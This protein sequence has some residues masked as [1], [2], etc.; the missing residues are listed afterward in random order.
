M[1]AMNANRTKLNKGTQKRVCWPDIFMRLDSGNKKS[2]LQRP[3]CRV[4]SAVETR[5]WKNA[6][7]EATPGRNYRHILIFSQTRACQDSEKNTYYI[8][9][10][11]QNHGL[12]TWYCLPLLFLSWNRWTDAFTT[13]RGLRAFT[14]LHINTPHSRFCNN[15]YDFKPVYPSLQVHT[16]RSLADYGYGGGYSTTSY[17]A[18]GG[19]DGGG[20][21]GGSQANSQETPGGTK[22]YIFCLVFGIVNGVSRGTDKT[23]FDRLQSNNW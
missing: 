1:K 23:L 2:L 6:R 5:S 4:W 19:A 10:R 14:R 3:R 12:C 7:R 8:P 20:F 16:H 15:G 21:V 18:Q 13:L 9:S 17:A 11:Y 22:V